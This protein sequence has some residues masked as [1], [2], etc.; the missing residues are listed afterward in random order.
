MEKDIDE[1]QGRG[2]NVVAIRGKKGIRS[3]CDEGGQSVEQDLASR[4]NKSWGKGGWDNRGVG[5]QN[6]KEIVP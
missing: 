3:K 4:G 5:R 1:M 6:R 2:N